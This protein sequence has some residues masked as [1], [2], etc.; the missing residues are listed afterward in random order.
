MEIL[1]YKK[2]EHVTINTAALVLKIN[3]SLVYYYA[4]RGRLTMICIDKVKLIELDSL[5][6]LNDYLAFRYKK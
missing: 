5:M 2:K 3:I 6:K 4:K 1:T